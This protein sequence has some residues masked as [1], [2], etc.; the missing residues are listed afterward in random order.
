MRY[1]IFWHISTSAVVSGLSKKI[2]VFC[3]KK[4][5]ADSEK[6]TAGVEGK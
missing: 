6:I 1:W 3:K 2:N 4:K 5:Q